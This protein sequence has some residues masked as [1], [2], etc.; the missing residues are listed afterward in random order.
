MAGIEDVDRFLGL[1]CRELAAAD[2]RFE[3]GGRPPAV[4]ET[5]KVF[6]ELSDGWRLVVLFGRARND[7]AELEARLST[8]VASFEDTL[9]GL[10]RGAPVPPTPTTSAVASELDQVLDALCERTTAV[11]AFVLDEQSPAVW[12]S[13][14][15]AAWLGDAQTALTLGTAIHEA[16]TSGIDPAQWVA[17]PNGAAVPALAEVETALRQLLDNPTEAALRLAILE[18]VRVCRSADG[19]AFAPDDAN[20]TMVRRFAGIYRLVLVLGPKFS[21][22]QVASTLSKALPVVERLVT[23]LPPLD[24]VPRGA[25]VIKFRPD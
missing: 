5:T 19:D 15:A 11:A 23:E 1:V 3:L 14:A 7:R 6:I 9:A 24:P 17:D 18:A 25:R 10:A 13:S 22:L 20:T 2:A 12:G 4:T 16:R 8:L 21:E